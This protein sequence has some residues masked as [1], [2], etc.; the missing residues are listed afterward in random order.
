MARKAVFVFALALAF[1]GPAFGQTDEQVATRLTPTLHA[2]DRAADIPLEQAY[3]YQA[4]LARQEKRLNATWAQVI[5]RRPPEQR[6]A[7]RRSE[8]QWIKD[9]DK[10]CRDEAADYV[11]ATAALMFNVCM[12]NEAIRRTMWLETAH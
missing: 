1:A 9:R 6:E 7:L 8:R 3:C 2:C 10:D 5:G 11:H 12:T 4:E